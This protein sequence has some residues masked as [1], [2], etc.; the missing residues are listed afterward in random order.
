MSNILIAVG[1]HDLRAELA[2]MCDAL[3]RQT[4]RVDTVEEGVRRLKDREY[5]LVLTDLC[6][7]D[8]IGFELFDA[9]RGGCRL[10]L[11]GRKQALTA[12]ERVLKH[13]LLSFLSAPVDAASLES[14]VRELDD[15]QGLKA[16]IRE[17]RKGIEAGRCGPLVGRSPVMKEVFNHLALAGPR[18]A[19]VLIVGESGSGKELAAWA[20]HDLSPRREG[21]LVAVNCGAISPTLMESELFGHERGSFTGATG[22]HRGY[23]EQA[24][25][26]T[27]FLDEITEM[28]PE[29]QVK[30]LRVLETSQVLRIGAEEERRVE[31]RIL[32]ATNRKPEEAIEQ[33][34]LR[35]DLYYRLKV[36]SVKLPPLRERP[37]D[38]PL[39][40]QHFLEEVIQR[41]GQP[42]EFSEAA[43][44]AL[45]EHLWPGNARELRNAIYTASLLSDGVIEVEH[46]PPTVTS[47][48]AFI[49]DSG[50]GPPLRVGATIKEMER[51]LI[52]STLR[53]M[54]G[55]KTRAADLLGVS[56]KTV[57]NRLSEYNSME[58]ES[59]S[60]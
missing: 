46:L 16:R 44:Q 12:A 34:K 32:A 9:V 26:G 28:P 6:L 21:P 41:E 39:L 24:D 49:G 35:E 3:P 38:V 54:D 59:A 48:D 51:R 14:L 36:L 58:T 47:E 2:G 40:A 50:Q 37:G 60:N 45:E 23:F 52:L 57:Y 20:L 53:H 31:V 8:G 17:W 30:L 33:G 7:A 42:R 13:P 29:L 43:M 4:D 11:V 18:N 15:A 10:V 5:D 19:P 22:T 25:G 56:V 27:L 55:N 1:D